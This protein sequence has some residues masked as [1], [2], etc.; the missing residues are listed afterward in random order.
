[1]TYGAYSWQNHVVYHETFKDYYF[2]WTLILA[3][4]KGLHYNIH[5]I[6][7]NELGKS[8]NISPCSMEI[9]GPCLR[10][11]LTIVFNVKMYWNRQEAIL[12]I[13]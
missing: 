5:M 10:P 3:D 9:I 13:D 11:P 2:S 12:L 4:P 8:E 7:K 6:T 1:M